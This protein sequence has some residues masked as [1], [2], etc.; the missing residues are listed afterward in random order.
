MME[1]AE[2]GSL[3]NGGCSSCSRERY[4]TLHVVNCV[5]QYK[6]HNHEMRSNL[7]SVDLFTVRMN[8]YMFDFL[9]NVSMHN[10]LHCL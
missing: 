10:D 1:Y 5:L 7:V 6:D 3:Y 9:N 4:I 8:S 2:G